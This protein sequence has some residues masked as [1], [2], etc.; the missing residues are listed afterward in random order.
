MGANPVQIDVGEF[1]EP[2]EIVE[3]DVLDGTF[4]SAS[5]APTGPDFKR[6]SFIDENPPRTHRILHDQLAS[7]LFPGLTSP[8]CLF[9][10]NQATAITGCSIRRAVITRSAPF[11]GATKTVRPPETTRVRMW[12]WIR[13]RRVRETGRG[14]GQLHR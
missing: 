2:I 6:R 12:S 10:A 3:D 4:T 11:L 5:R 9:W 1:N 8:G 13:S 14:R 7:P